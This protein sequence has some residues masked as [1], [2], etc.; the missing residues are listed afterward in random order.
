MDRRS[1]VITCEAAEITEMAD[2]LSSL[3]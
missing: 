2:I 1:H 3:K